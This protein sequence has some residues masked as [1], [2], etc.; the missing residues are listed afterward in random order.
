MIHELFVIET[1]LRWQMVDIS[2]RITGGY[3]D[4]LVFQ[5]RKKKLCAGVL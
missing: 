4:I 5:K 1:S 3:W 2:K